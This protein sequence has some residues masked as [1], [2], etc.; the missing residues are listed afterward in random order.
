MFAFAPPSGDKRTSNAP[1]PGYPVHEYMTWFS[2]RG[3]SRRWRTGL[4][5]APRDLRAGPEQ[6]V[7]LL[8]DLLEDR[9]E[10]FRPVRRAHDVGVHRDRHHARR[11]LGVGVDLL[12][13][14]HGALVEFR[15]L[16]VL[17][18]HHGHVVAFL[19]IGDVEDRLA[20]GHEPHRLIV[21]HPV[22]DV[23]VALLGQDIGGLP[24]FGQPGPEPSARPLAGRL[25]DDLGT[26]ADVGALVFDLLHVALG[27]AVADELPF[28]LDAGLDDIGKGFDRGAVDVHD[29][30]NLELVI[31]LQQ[32]PEADAVAVFVPAPV[33]DIRH[34]RTA[35]GRREHGAR[36]GLGRIPF[37]HVGD[38]PDRHARAVRQLERLAIDDGRI[39]EA[40]VRQHADGRLGEIHGGCLCPERRRGE[41][42]SLQRTGRR[43]PE[44]N[45]GRASRRTAYAR[46]RRRGGPNRTAAMAT[47]WIASRRRPGPE[48]GSGEACG[49]TGS[50]PCWAAGACE[51]CSRSGNS[52]SALVSRCGSYC[53][54]T[55]GAAKTITAAAKPRT[56]V[57]GEATSAKTVPNE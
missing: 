8:A 10:M 22:G 3:A 54:T 23:V 14:I 25:G 20:A 6:H 48:A 30:G 51:A 50:A 34:G 19:G 43:H 16:V 17:D 53:S 18:Q 57:T 39:V 28:A 40:V 21:E 36:H 45:D 12:E 7:L 33:G 4:A 49:G 9:A 26:L 27:I 41:A 55:A 15:G 42:Q 5:I 46:L 56:Y 31:D 37:L 2:Y 52:R 38:G 29:A 44:S 24:G 35:G 13:L 32:A 1:N 47:P 11:A